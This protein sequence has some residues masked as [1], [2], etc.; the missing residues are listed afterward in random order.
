MNSLRNMYFPSS[1]SPNTVKELENKDLSGYIEMY[2][3]ESQIN[4]KSPMFCDKYKIEWDS[5]G[6]PNEN[7]LSDKSCFVN[8]NSTTTT[9]NEPINPPGLLNNNRTDVTHYDWLLQKETVSNSL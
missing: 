8:Q 9:Y 5:Y 6:V 2:L 3:P 1:I 4:I 7:D